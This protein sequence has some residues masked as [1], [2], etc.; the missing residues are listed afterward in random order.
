MSFPEVFE[1]PATLD[2]TTA[3]C[4]I[5]VHVNTAYKLA[6]RNEFPCRIWR[7]GWR[8]RVPT[9]ELMKAMGIE[10]CPV[11]IADVD[12]GADFAGSID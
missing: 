9:M 3:A 6:Q 8:Y 4:A 1:L 12:N 5:G 10:S 7:L 11:D 2:M